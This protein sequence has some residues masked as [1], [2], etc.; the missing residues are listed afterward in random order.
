MEKRIWE[1]VCQI[2]HNP[3]SLERQ[4]QDGK[5]STVT[6]ENV[7][8]LKTQCQKLRRGMERL[9]D[10]FAEGVIDREQFTIRMDRTKARISEIETKLSAQAADQDH[11][12][13]VRSLRTRLAALSNHLQSHLNEADWTTKREIIRALVQRIE[14]GTTSVVVVLRLP[15]ETG[16]GPWSPLW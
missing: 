3:E 16:T 7:D 9:I 5:Q 10:S 11:R 8:A 2:V 12:V 13:H 6:S 4:D 1:Y 15:A 14:I